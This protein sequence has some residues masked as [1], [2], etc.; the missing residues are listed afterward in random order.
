MCNISV[1]AKGQGPV[2]SKDS[3]AEMLQK[4]D[5]WETKYHSEVR[6][7]AAPNAQRICTVFFGVSHKK[8][9]FSEGLKKCQKLTN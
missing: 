2:F 4:S 8:E 6:K 1:I 5:Q 3:V 9:K 7:M